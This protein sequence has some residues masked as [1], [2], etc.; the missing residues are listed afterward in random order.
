V[1]FPD[2][3]SEFV[4]LLA[5]HDRGIY[6]YILTLMADSIATQEV[7]QETSLTLWQKFDDFRPGSN[8]L[9]W[10]CRV[11]YFEVLRYRKRVRR[12]RLRFGDNLMHILAEELS[13]S[14]EILQARRGALPGCMERLPPND[15]EL[16]EQR[17]AGQETIL[18]I[19]ERTGRPVNT[20]YKALE[21][22]RHALM[23]CIEESVANSDTRPRPAAAP[24][25]Q[26]PLTGSEK[27]RQS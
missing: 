3:T 14:E 15:R 1:A 12:E 24:T 5:R 2:R 6:K 10:A 25:K 21:R 18:Q 26:Q 27:G 17:Y 20:L 19:A 23:E 9:A 22:I 13:A 7:Y 16:V 8:F 11:A 4:S